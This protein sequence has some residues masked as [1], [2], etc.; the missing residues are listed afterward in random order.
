MALPE[1]CAKTFGTRTKGMG[2]LIVLLAAALSFVAY[3]YFAVT[4]VLLNVDG[5]T[6]SLETQ[7]KTVGQVL[8]ENG[9]YVRAHDILLPDADRAVASGMEIYLQRA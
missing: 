8:A 3:S 4:P 2:I 7:A 6:V 1:W 9:L 5:E